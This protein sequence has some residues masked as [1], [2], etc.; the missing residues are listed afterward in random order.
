MNEALNQQSY[1]NTLKR[2]LIEQLSLPAEHVE[3]LPHRATE[4]LNTFSEI[5]RCADLPGDA[6][7]RRPR[8]WRARVSVFD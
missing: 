4:Q 6:I 7:A 3:A 5:V 1:S 8:G 2:C